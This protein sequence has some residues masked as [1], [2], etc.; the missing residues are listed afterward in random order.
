VL[1]VSDVVCDL[2]K[3]EILAVLLLVEAIIELSVEICGL[4]NEQVDVFD[5]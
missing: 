2:F 3:E 1:I 4:L 5:V